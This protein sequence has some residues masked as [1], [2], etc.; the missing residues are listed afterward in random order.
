MSYPCDTIRFTTTNKK[1][2]KM[3]IE[4]F[5]LSPRGRAWQ[6]GYREWNKKPRVYVYPQGEGVWE[7]LQ[8]RRNRPITEFRKV[9]YQALAQLGYTKSDVKL[10]WSQFAGC[11][12]PCSP[13]FVMD[14]ADKNIGRGLEHADLS[15]GFTL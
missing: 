12:C 10:R 2:T 5:N 3:K 7:N 11:T 1:G 4:T 9:A 13:G 15:V 6:I 8:N 14:F